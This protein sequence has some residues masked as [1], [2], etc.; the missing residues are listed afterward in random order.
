MSKAKHKRDNSTLQDKVALRRLV[1]S[2]FNHRP[3]VVL[4]T[5][6]G[7]GVVYRK[8]YTDCTGV[9]FESSAR[10]A[11][12]LAIQRPNWAVYEGDA[13]QCMLAGAPVH[14]Q[15]DLVDID[16]Y[17]SALEYIRAFFTSPRSFP[18]Q[19]ALAVNDG[20]PYALQ[21]FGPGNL[22]LVQPYAARYGWTN[23]FWHYE[24]II[25]DWLP[26]EAAR[27]GYQVV[28]LVYRAV[29]SNNRMAHYAALLK[30][31]GG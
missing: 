31:T 18:A 20:A 25:R 2:W 27:A 12:L 3:L 22:R 4:E 19:L 21:A 26:R 14:I 13:V 10:K 6:G 1:R 7:K 16:P 23:L 17:G 29:G 15:P 28:E 5:N 8:V 24:S 30:R 9:V 11:E